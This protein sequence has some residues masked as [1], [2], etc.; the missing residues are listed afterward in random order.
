[1]SGG[2]PTWVR[3]HT[4]ETEVARLQAAID[5]VL[6]ELREMTDSACAADVL[7]VADLYRILTE[8]RA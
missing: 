5:A 4:L 6:A 8:E 1:M 3:V 7:R 2:N